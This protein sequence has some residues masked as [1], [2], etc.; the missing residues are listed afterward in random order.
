[1]NK[2]TKFWTNNKDSIKNITIMV[3]V[4]LAVVAIYNINRMNKI[5][6]VNNITE[7]FYEID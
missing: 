5:M 4:P 2:F 6:E 7:L 1:M 3:A